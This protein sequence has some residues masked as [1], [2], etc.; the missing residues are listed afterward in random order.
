MAHKLC[1]L[2]SPQAG[3]D[4]AP[5]SLWT[6]THFW[7]LLVASSACLSFGHPGRGLNIMDVSFLPGA[8]RVRMT[9]SL[10]NL[11]T[12]RLTV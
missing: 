12:G 9:E 10:N 8:M 1:P 4:S 7:S 5:Q 2:H 6:R 3:P 11:M